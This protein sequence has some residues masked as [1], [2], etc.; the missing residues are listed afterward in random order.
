MARQGTA[1]VA[2]SVEL[3]VVTRNG[4]VESRHIGS[5]IVLSSEGEAIVSLGNPSAKVFAR[6]AL[7]PLQSLALHTAGLSLDD[8]EERAMSL[9]SHGGSPEHIAIVQRMLQAGGLSDAD[10]QCPVDWPL[11]SAAKVR[12]IAGGGRPSSVAHCCSGKHAAMLRTCAINGWLTDG[13][14]SPEHEVQQAIRDTVQRFTGESPE[15]IAVDGCGAPTFALSLAGIARAYRRM[16]TANADSPF[17]LH[18]QAA[19]LLE[20]ARRHPWV[21]EAEGRGDSALIAGLGCFAKFGAEGV[22]VIAAPDG[23]VAVVKI[24]DG[25]LRA[26]RLV[27]VEL[28]VQT[29]AISREA[30]DAM[31]PALRTSVTGG[32][33]VVGHVEVSFQ[34]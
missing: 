27:A 6:S 33:E 23:T 14:L 19:L 29:G 12:L 15:P 13:Y 30:L 24:L 26:A 18:R 21:V 11:D 9:A 16:A 2:E 8:D 25:T 17:P 3:A 32:F 10:L 34:S 20:S 31:L 4:F 5:A 28:L 22:S 7:K 1:G